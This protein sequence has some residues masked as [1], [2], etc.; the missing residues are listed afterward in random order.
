MVNPDVHVYTEALNH[1][2]YSSKRKKQQPTENQKNTKS[3]I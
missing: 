3:E 1:R 2:K